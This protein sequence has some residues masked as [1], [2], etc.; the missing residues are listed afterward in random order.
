[1]DRHA[2]SEAGDALPLSQY[3]V[4]AE[5][6][7]RLTSDAVFGSNQVRAVRV[8]VIP[9]VRHGGTRSRE[10]ERERES[11]QS[12]HML[13]RDTKST[14]TASRCNWQ[15]GRLQPFHLPEKEQVSC[16]FDGI[17]VKVT[18]S[19]TCWF[20]SPKNFDANLSCFSTL[21]H[22]ATCSGGANCGAFGW[23][24]CESPSQLQSKLYHRFDLLL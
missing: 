13:S 4:R 19:T 8:P 10:I 20:T 6:M 1:M 17:C 9:H 7:G 18:C 23:H 24:G 11:Q 16:R 2:N 14:N 22:Y 12:P 21:P 5:M 15:A 3:D